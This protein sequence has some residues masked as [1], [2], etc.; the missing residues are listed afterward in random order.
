MATKTLG[1]DILDAAERLVD[2]RGGDADG[3]WR[4]MF[5]LCARADAA[6]RG[7]MAIDAYFRSVYANGWGDVAATVARREELDNAIAAWRALV[8][9]PRGT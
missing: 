3:R 7:M 4:V 6:E 9:S 2:K 1:A 5:A 8:E